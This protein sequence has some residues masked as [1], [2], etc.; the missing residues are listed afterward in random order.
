M[1]KMLLELSAHDRNISMPRD[2]QMRLAVL[3]SSRPKHENTRAAP[4]ERRD[5]ILWDIGASELVTVIANAVQLSVVSVIQERVERFVEIHR[6][7]GLISPPVAS[8]R[9]QQDFFILP[10]GRQR[11][12]VYRLSP[13]ACF[14]LPFSSEIDT[15]RATR[16]GQLPM[17]IPAISIDGACADC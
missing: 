1:L 6:C 7:L 5:G 15:A 3:L 17:V 16:S 13:R 12:T 4:A 11:L 8:H 14:R 9:R 2:N 10:A